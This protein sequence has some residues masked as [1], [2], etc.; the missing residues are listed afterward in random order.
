[1][2]IF[3]NFTIYFHFLV[4]QF[5][6][7]YLIYININQGPGWGWWA[8]VLMVLVGPPKKK[9]PLRGVVVCYVYLNLFIAAIN[10][11]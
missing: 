2:T 8:P 1:M 10:A 11:F 5:F 4:F 3:Y 7:I 9:L 6:I